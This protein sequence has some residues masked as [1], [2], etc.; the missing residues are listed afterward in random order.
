MKKK[1]RPRLH[2]RNHSARKFSEEIVH[3]QKSRICPSPE[4][5]A[6]KNRIEALLYIAK[7]DFKLTP[8]KC[9]CGMWHNTSERN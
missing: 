7:N 1:G 6:F 3:R 4:K 2:K 9:R 8:Y 5:I